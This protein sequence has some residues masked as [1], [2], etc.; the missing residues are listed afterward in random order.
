M[1]TK[2]FYSHTVGERPVLL[3]PI[4]LSVVNLKVNSQFSHYIFCPQYS[5]I[6]RTEVLQYASS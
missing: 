2:E 3:M 6:L 5:A 4:F 1:Y